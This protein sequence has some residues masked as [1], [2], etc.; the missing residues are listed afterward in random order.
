M[1]PVQYPTVT[2]VA[3]QKDHQVPSSALDSTSTF[4]YVFTCFNAGCFCGVFC[5]NFS[6]R[7]YT[8]VLCSSTFSSLSIWRIEHHLF[9]FSPSILDIGDSSGTQ[10]GHYT[11]YF[12]ISFRGCG[13][14]S[15]LLILL[16]SCWRPQF[17]IFWDFLGKKVGLVRF[18]LLLVSGSCGLEMFLWRF[19]GKGF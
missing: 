7:S 5:W 12:S 4:F 10:K 19:V 3:D 2:T 16:Y 9:I 11:P 18:I 6:F 1:L 15:R 13:K 17:G 14:A 8:P